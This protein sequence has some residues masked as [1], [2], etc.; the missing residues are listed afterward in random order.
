V[1]AP[2]QAGH[3]GVQGK[4]P[5]GA[6]TMTTPTDLTTKAATSPLRVST[7][8]DG[9]LLRLRLARPKAN[10]IDV[11]MAEAVDAALAAHADDR[12][13]RAVLLDHEGPHFS[14]GAS[15]PEHMP[16]PCAAMLAGMHA[17]VRR[18]V[19]FP[20]PVLV[21]IRG[22]CLGGGL[23]LACSG[24]L[25]FA[26]TDAKFG[27]PEIKLAVFAPAASCLLPER[28]GQA[29]ADELLVS[30]RTVEADEALAI[31]LVNKVAAD[32][33]AAA[34]DWFDGH[35]AP[36]SASAL[37]RAVH[38]SRADYARRIHDKLEWVEKYYLEDL[39]RLEDP[40][41][42]LTAFMAKRK[43]VWQDR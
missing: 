12:H 26:G 2:G 19:E 41:E 6:L 37:R 34:L 43:P 15:I 27:Q 23:E 7:E 24:H 33:E 11:A 1:D 39:M 32:P 3:D 18:T 20:L 14:Y 5:L 17:M 21:V 25:L 30:G 35:L 28:I 42:G 22:W 16:E 31:G 36:Q 29:R 38:A 9:A 13:L 10:L 8:R 4:A 40:I